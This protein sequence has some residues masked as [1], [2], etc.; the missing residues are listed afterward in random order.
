MTLNERIEAFENDWRAAQEAGKEDLLAKLRLEGQAI[1]VAVRATKP[2]AGTADG[3]DVN[4]T[5]KLDEAITKAVG[6]EGKAAFDAWMEVPEPDEPP[7]TDDLAGDVA[8]LR[9]F[10][11]EFRKKQS[12]YAPATLQALRQAEGGVLASIGRRVG[13]AADEGE[14]RAGAILHAWDDG[15]EAAVTALLEA[16]EREGI[17]SG[18]DA[19]KTNPKPRRWLV[20]GWLPEGRIG[21]INGKGESGKSRLTLQL[22]AKLASGDPTWIPGPPGLAVPDPLPDVEGDGSPLIPVVVATWEDEADELARRLHGM[23]GVGVDPKKLAGA[24]HHADMSGAGPL[25]AP[26][27]AGG[28]HVS[29]MGALTGAGRWLRRWCEEQSARLLVVDPLAAAYACS[30]N[31]RGLVRHFMSDWDNWARRTGCAVLIVAHPS[32]DSRGERDY[33]TSGSTD[34]H[35]ASRFVWLMEYKEY[36]KKHADEDDGDVPEGMRLEVTKSNYADGDKPPGVWLVPDG[37]GWQ[38]I[39]GYGSPLWDGV[40]PELAKLREA[41]KAPANTGRRSPK[42]RRRGDNGAAKGI[43]PNKGQHGV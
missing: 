17:D 8:L 16:W 39:P 5:A 38:V 6:A 24:L 37:A 28:G 29:T 14:D 34:W 2:E 21:I 41:L 32:K 4:A 12:K 36:R 11:A 25:W 27:K 10:R 22:A 35:G 33:H 7:P 40:A 43:D 42:D 23:S 26:S 31:D 1:G 19:W 18:F 15:G 30:E 20:P 9:G 13:Q 3:G